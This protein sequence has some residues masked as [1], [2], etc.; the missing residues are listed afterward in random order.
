VG[1]ANRPKLARVRRWLVR[2]LGVDRFSA[3]ERALIG[4]HLALLG[5]PRP[6]VMTVDAM[7]LFYIPPGPFQ[8]GSG[9]DD[10]MADDDERPLYDQSIDYGYWLARYPVTVAQFAAFCD[11]SGFTPADPDALQDDSNRPVRWVS[12]HEALAFCDWLTRRWRD[13]GRLL[14]SDQVTLPSEPEWEKAARGGLEIPATPLVGE[15]SIEP[16][17]VAM[18]ANVDPHRRY[19]WGRE[20]DPERASFGGLIGDTSAVG[21]FPAGASPCGCEEMSGNV[22]E[23]T[24]SL[25]GEDWSKP[26][27]GYPYD[28]G[29]GC[30]R[31]EAPNA[32]RRV[33]RG[34]AFRNLDNIVRCACRARY[35][36]DYRYFVLGFRVVLS[37]F[38]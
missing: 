4:H 5:D 36:P 15:A 20:A 24:R 6:E 23:W 11:E 27:F 29:D 16:A 2:L 30:E 31:L 21:A 19:P 34:G 7:Q 38:L 10:E 25:W 37:P 28:S 22:W 26:Q 3:R 18:L 9:E 1:D 14:A 13:Q 17:A 32:V 35:E 12:W 33:L 8:M